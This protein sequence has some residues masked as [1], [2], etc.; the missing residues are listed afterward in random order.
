MT[1]IK[2]IAQKAGVS[3]STVSR[4]LNNKKWVR[5][6]I[7]EKICR[8]AKEMEY[9]PDSSA[10]ALVQKRAGAIGL[11]IP[12]ASEFAFRNPYYTL[13]ILGLS[14]LTTKHNYN[15][16]L[17]INDQDSYASLYHR[18]MVD[19]IIIIGNRI[20]DDK[21]PELVEKKI[22]A[23]IVPGYPADSKIKLASVN[24]ENF[25]S[26]YR[27][28]EY[29]IGLGHRK[30]SF[31]LGEM[32]SYYSI[33]R[34]SAYKAAFKNNKL[35]YDEKYI[36]ESDFSKTAGYRLMDSLLNLPDPPSSLICI[37][38]MVALGAM[39]QINER[40][41]K[42]PEDISVIAIGSSDLYEL[43]SPPITTIRSPAI[44]MGKT[45]AEILI[46]HIEKG[47]CDEEHIVI[48]SDF[49]IRESTGRW[50]SRRQEAI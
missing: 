2:E 11:I 7:C 3:Y 34:L 19:G 22:P 5:P 47:C 12:R 40:G 38:D 15:L 18:R 8:I 39:N 50:Q 24:S 20:D 14:E 46:K 36:V 37:G 28:V 6:E 35:Y 17:S 27:A 26:V 43:F 13:F 23:V 45:A 9:F 21:I 29:L 41:M 49:I 42:I 44:Q 32:N 33:E 16:V 25:K 30:I 31:I 1:T 4:A 48:P 10:K